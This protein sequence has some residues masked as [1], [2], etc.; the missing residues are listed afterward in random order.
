MFTQLDDAGALHGPFVELRPIAEDVNA[1]M[2]A[3]GAALLGSLKAAEIAHHL[4]R[5][6]QDGSLY[7][8]PALR[9]ATVG[10]VRAALRELYR[11]ATRTEAIMVAD[12]LNTLTDAQLRALFNMTQT[13]V[14][15]LRLNKLQ[16][17]ADSA[18]KIRAEQGV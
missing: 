11:T 6:V 15:A 5:I 4:S 7:A 12:F 9:Y 1:Y 14:T 3:H 8:I 13:E 16:P 2:A 18:A 10:D 17:T